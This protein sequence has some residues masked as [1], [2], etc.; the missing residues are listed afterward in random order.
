MLPR[1]IRNN[2][3]LN[4]RVGN[5]W[6]GEVENPTD[7][8]F[9]QFTCMHYGLRAGFILLRRYIERYHLNTI[10]EIISRWA[11]S[12][13]NN[14]RAYINRVS[15]RVGISA[16]EK[17]SFND[18]KTMVALVDAMVLQECGTTIANNLIEDAYTIV[19]NDDYQKK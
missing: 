3:P 8:D 12:T 15:E 14:T 10:T 13:E 9:E 16:L 18:R 4:I 5:K 7:Q 19:V 6:K 11:P 17:I 1:G 2:N